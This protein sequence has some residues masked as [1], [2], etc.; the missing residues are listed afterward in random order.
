MSDISPSAIRAL[1]KAIDSKKSKSSRK[2]ESSQSAVIT[3]VDENGM[4]WFHIP[5]GAQETPAKYSA[6]DV[7]KGD[8]VNVTVQ[9]GYARIDGNISAPAASDR[10]VQKVTVT[11]KE[12]TQG[13]FEKLDAEK[14]TI[15]DLRA[16][17]ADID[18]LEVDTAKIHD[19][20][21]EELSASVGYISDL[22]AGN[23][24]AQNIIT[25][26]ST[27]GSLDANYA[28]ISDGVIDNATIDNANVSGLAAAYAHISNG[29]IDNAS[30]N[31]ANVT[32]LTAAYAQIDAANIDTATI[33]NA[34]ADQILVQTGLISHQAD[35]FTL[36]AIQVDAANITAGTIDVQR[37]I[38]TV[39]GHKYMVHIDP[40]TSQPTYQKLDGDI[41]EDLTITADKI[42]AG[43]I[44]AQK[45]TTENLVGTG[46]WINLHEGTF[47]YSNQL[48]GHG[49]SWDGTSL[50][51]SGNVQV[52]NSS[53]PM[54]NML[55]NL[56]GTC[57]TAA[58]TTQKDVVCPECTV[59]YAGLTIAVKFSTANSAAAPTLKVGSTE[60]KPI[61]VDNAVTSSSNCLFWNT[62]ATI[63]FRYDGVNWTVA[64]EP[65]TY[66]GISTTAAATARKTSS[67]ASSVVRKGTTATIRFTYAHTGTSIAT[68]YISG[69]TAQA[70]NVYLNGSGVVAGNSW[71]D[72]EAVPLVFN[73]QYWYC[74][75]GAQGE[76]GPQGATGATGAQG[77]EGPRGA[78]GATGAT[79]AQG[80]QGP[81]GATGATGAQGEE[82]PRGATGATGAQGE[83]GETGPEANIVV[84]V[85]FINYISNE[86]TLNAILYVDSVEKS[87]G[88]QYK[89]YRDG[90][91]IN[92]STYPSAA[93]N[94]LT[95]PAAL[96][97]AHLYS[98]VCTWT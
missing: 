50:N 1:E 17:K 3:R 16:V 92:T 53:V 90:V 40:E 28:H 45:I 7:A 80:E 64:D 11:L 18:E 8:V 59:L 89:W 13:I 98:C 75:R 27:I 67:I 70:K 55:T 57:S 56:Y 52:G 42:V 36:D 84:R 35:I 68:L 14:A 48:S 69:N 29:V 20:T 5:G 65:T 83:Q 44:T 24:T 86:A 2:R 77:E 79:G 62:N 41:V 94:T 63:S 19:L 25:D 23:V 87:S 82:G 26:H 33:R 66:Y 95:I 43:A 38:V 61:W 93:T 6:V 54:A 21:A 47:E 31:H 39:D 30:I 46:G 74:S 58:A 78:T 49:I 9:N 91:E 88:V 4:A 76:Q 85:T 97:I 51:I 96:G 81:Q 32:G 34:W 37:L 22:T 60:A 12:E 72:G 73:G 71:A 15:K 10:T